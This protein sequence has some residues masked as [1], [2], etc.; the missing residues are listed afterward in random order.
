M[1]SDDSTR[2][3]SLAALAALALPV[4]EALNNATVQ[5]LKAAVSDPALDEELAL[6]L[7]KR[8]DLPPEVLEQLGKNSSVMKSRKLKLAVSQHPRTPR[9]VS[10]PLGRQLFTFD[11]MQLA[12]APLA[13]AD[14]KKAAE[15][16][17]LTR[18]E[19]VSV[20]EKIS[21]ARR[22]SARVATALLLDPE[23][24]VTEVA[25]ENASLTEA[26]VI[27]A[28]GR[29][30]APA[31]F[32]HAVCC[33]AKWSLRQAVRIALLRNENTPSARALELARTLP[34]AL[35]E[36]VLERSSLSGNLRW[37]RLKEDKGKG[38]ESPR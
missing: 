27:K 3:E 35:L 15:E 1:P 22:A 34:A 21:L 38:T 18:L 12:L 2:T 29:R 4:E 32:V 20:G 26:C 7:L 28:L 17:L 23:P 31:T 25:L 11:L 8:R 16:A 6:A 13:P 14:I 5:V 30:D 37:H 33:H 10:L 36:D 24:S 9:H 19:S